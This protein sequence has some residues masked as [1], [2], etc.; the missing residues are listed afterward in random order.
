MNNNLDAILLLFQ[1]SRSPPRTSFAIV[2]TI[3]PPLSEMCLIEVWTFSE[4]GCRFDHHVPCHPRFAR[5]T[6][7]PQARYSQ[8]PPLHVASPPSRSAND[9]DYA[10]GSYTNS[11]TQKGR[12][13]C[14]IRHIEHRVFREPIC[15]DCFLEETGVNKA[16]RQF[17]DTTGNALDGEAWLLESKVEIQV[18]EETTAQE[19]VTP[20][21]LLDDM[22]TPRVGIGFQSI[23]EGDADDEGEGEFEDD[24]RGRSTRRSAIDIKREH[25]GLATSWSNWDMKVQHAM[26]QAQA[27]ESSGGFKKA[28]SL[29]RKMKDTEFKNF[30]ELTKRGLRTTIDRAKVVASKARSDTSRSPTEM[31]WDCASSIVGPSVH[32]TKVSSGAVSKVLHDRDPPGEDKERI[33]VRKSYLADTDELTALPL[34]GQVVIWN[35]QNILSTVS[36]A[37]EESGDHNTTP[38]SISSS[39]H[40]L[41]QMSEAKWEEHLRQDLGA[42]K[43]KHNRPLSSIKAGDKSDIHFDV[44][45]E[46]CRLL[47][48]D[49]DQSAALTTSDASSG[50]WTGLRDGQRLDEELAGRCRDEEDDCKR[51]FSR[52]AMHSS[53][54]AASKVSSVSL[55]DFAHETRVANVGIFIPSGQSPSR[56]AHKPSASSIASFT[57][58]FS[59]SPQ[60]SPPRPSP[61]MRQSL[62]FHPLTTMLQI[63]T[64]TRPNWK[65]RDSSLNSPPLTSP[66]RAGL[67]HI[68]LRC[69]ST[70]EFTCVH[71]YECC[72][73]CRGRVGTGRI[74]SCLCDEHIHC[75]AKKV[76]VKKVVGMDVCDQCV[77]AQ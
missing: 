6:T 55:A 20:E 11:K 45:G 28:T 51:L 67:E 15:D 60:T 74:V 69:S 54:S 26:N 61:R 30:A 19:G 16:G 32:V 48:T 75:Q 41:I 64:P 76:M 37:S 52:L 13:E 36:T 62:S 12:R 35:P 17:V 27:E 42:R 56:H 68:P 21:T 2:D 59:S 57:T 53:P 63:A 23:G 24:F 47:S 66:Y 65:A 29:A 50:N 58:A 73:I 5:Y 3:Y 40:D 8:S 39:A 38:T 77:A 34:C 70:S 22:P 71:E 44:G 46:G 33:M 10:W 43:I 7:P 14:S 49:T 31:E 18:D 72:A 25:L 4:C 9:E 1:P